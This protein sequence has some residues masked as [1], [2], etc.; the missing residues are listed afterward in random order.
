MKPNFNLGIL[1][2][3]KK[4]YE[5]SPRTPYQ[6]LLESAEVPEASKA[7]LARRKNGSDPVDLN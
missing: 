4:I 1:G 2:R 7:E 3:Y 6:R 5:K